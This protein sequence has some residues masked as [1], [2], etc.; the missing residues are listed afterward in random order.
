[1]TIGAWVFVIFIGVIGLSIAGF[2]LWGAVT[3]DIQYDKGLKIG[4]S[5]ATAATVLI[6]ALISGIYIWYR[7]NSESGRRA[8]KD[9]QS[10]LSGGIERTVSV[11]DVNG[12]LI[13][14]YSGKFD[15]ETDRESY[16]LFDDEDGNRHMIYYTTGTIIVDEK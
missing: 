12:Q 1:M 16:I 11:Y 3:T 2:L 4:L 9:Q 7:L 5:V 15:I 13:K 14:E 6:T 10:N 8:L